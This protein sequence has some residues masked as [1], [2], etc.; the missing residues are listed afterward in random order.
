MFDTAVGRA[1]GAAELTYFH[2]PVAEKRSVCLTG[3]LSYNYDNTL[4]LKGRFSSDLH[5]GGMIQFEERLASIVLRATGDVDLRAM[6][7][8]P[9]VGFQVVFDPTWK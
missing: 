3:G 1:T 9:R 6:G 5:V 2:D 4:T 7:Q 8:Q